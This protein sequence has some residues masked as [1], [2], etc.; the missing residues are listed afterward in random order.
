MIELFW[1]INNFEENISFFKF[2]QV[3]FSGEMENLFRTELD[4]IFLIE[5][6]SSK[7]YTLSPY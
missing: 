6:S 1:L 5:E 3:R 4:I 7:W 2:G